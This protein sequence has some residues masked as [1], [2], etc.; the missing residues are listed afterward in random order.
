MK[1]ARAFGYARSVRAF[2]LLV[3]ILTA[4]A[5]VWINADSTSPERRTRASPVPV[6]PEKRDEV[7]RMRAELASHPD[8]E[9]ELLRRLTKLGPRAAPAIPEIAQRL[10]DFGRYKH[11]YEQKV[12]MSGRLAITNW[13]RIDFDCGWALVAIGEKSI[14]TLIELLGS[15]YRDVRSV[16]RRS[17]RELAPAS[18][19][20]VMDAAGD[21]NEHRRAGVA[22]LL[23]LGA[24]T[25][26]EA[27]DTLIRLLDDEDS[28]VRC[29]AYKSLPKF[30]ALA[31]PVIGTRMRGAHRKDATD[32]LVRLPRA[33][34]RRAAAV[35]RQS[36]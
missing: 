15:E 34:R 17:L 19:P 22:D 29:R 21:S 11:E 23:G 35:Y 7:D 13:I 36:K 2:L 32:A 31:V 4:A 20:A 5:I 10:A 25:H 9:R 24:A 33:L 3:T 26:P 27:F 1:I 8:D 30:G 12:L 16:A 28:W 18:I 14:P 6:E